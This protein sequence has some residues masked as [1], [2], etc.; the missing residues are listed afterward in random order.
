MSPK[1]TA[2][3]DHD[4]LMQAIGRLT[5]LE[6]LIFGNIPDKCI[7][8]EERQKAT[9]NAIDEIKETQKGIFE[10]LNRPLLT[11]QTALINA[12]ISGS[13]GAGIAAIIVRHWK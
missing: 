3:N 5:S 8:E 11:A 7:R 10:R 6:K 2:S 1:T 9:A 4:E 13:T 12:L